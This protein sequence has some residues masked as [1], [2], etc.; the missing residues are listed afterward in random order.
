MGR[1]ALVRQYDVAAGILEELPGKTYRFEYRA[2]YHGPPVS[3]T[4]PTSER[5]H[6]FSKFPPVFEGLLPEGMQL[7][8]LLRLRKLDRSDHM[9]QLLAVGADVVGSLTILPEEE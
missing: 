8:A 4:M 2:D 1:K 9:G 3:L 5:V 7:E 6:E